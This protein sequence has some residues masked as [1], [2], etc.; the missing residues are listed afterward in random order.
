MKE[1]KIM[2]KCM[3]I[4][5]TL[6]LTMSYVT[7]SAG[8]NDPKA[9]IEDLL[10][11]HR[12]SSTTAQEHELVDAEIAYNN[13]KAN[14]NT[15]AP[16]SDVTESLLTDQILNKQ[17]FRRTCELEYLRGKTV[18][19][20]GSPSQALTDL[21]ISFNAD[22][23]DIDENYN[24]SDSTA[25]EEYSALENDL[26]SVYSKLSQ[27]LS[28]ASAAGINVL[29]DGSPYTGIDMD[30]VI[31]TMIAD[32]IANLMKSIGSVMF[33]TKNTYDT[34]LNGLFSDANIKLIGS[35]F[36][37]DFADAFAD[38]A[39]SQAIYDFMKSDN[40]L[41][42]IISSNNLSNLFTKSAETANTAISDIMAEVINGILNLSQMSDAKAGFLSTG[43]TAKSFTDAIKTIADVAEEQAGVYAR[44][45]NLNMLFGRY[46]KVYK[47]NDVAE[48]P[49]LL[50]ENHPSRTYDVKV[51]KG[52]Y[53]ASIIN[54]IKNV[55]YDDAAAQTESSSLSA[56][57]D[58]GELTFS[59]SSI[60]NSTYYMNIYRSGDLS[61]SVDFDTV[62]GY[63]G[64]LEIN[65][66]SEYKPVTS[67]SIRQGSEITIYDGSSEKLEAKISPIKAN[68]TSVSWSSSD[69][70][71][72]S[73]SSSGTIRGEKTG[74]ATITVTTNDG[75]HTASIKVT[76]KRRPGDG[77]SGGGVPKPPVVDG[78]KG[79]GV[80]TDKFTDVPETHWASEQINSLVKKGIIKGRTT[81][82]FDP[83]SPLTR[84]ELAIIVTG[85]MNIAPVE[86]GITYGDTLYHY[87]KNY[88][89]A[90]AKH[91]LMIGYDENS[92]NPDA[93]VTREQVISVLLRAV[94]L[95]GEVIN[96]GIAAL[97][98]DQILEKI[99]TIIGY[100]P[101][102]TITVYTDL[103][104]CSAWA[105]GYIE[106]AIA[107]GLTKGYEDNTIRP[108]VNATRAEAVVMV[109][110]ALGK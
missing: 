84:A 54:L 2:K 13:I 17:T 55:V 79:D 39:T 63:I 94:H 16:W 96:D 65:V 57:N 103:D 20:S 6:L 27:L 25:A 73:V 97:G 11:E 47:D 107:T 32:K 31:N 78:G 102:G 59:F 110:R 61:A 18:T 69:S 33:S 104:S 22:N 88:I 52:S 83:E 60:P 77:G 56:S 21:L 26:R 98:G 87:A 108:L 28:D 43:L 70:K 10:T 81:E 3:C 44:I 35:M 66:E 41:R 9:L 7:V 71:I 90:A 29:V 100:D 76:V 19:L 86:D 58:L 109:D 92:F 42:K 80:Y 50:D 105:K 68:S 46:M 1:I 37:K 24:F 82:T 106:V 64:S 30:S 14:A 49:I 99:I 67:V 36:G 34:A 12:E 4:I 53:S 91:G 72:V 62:Y 38:N 93:Y 95:K 48:L 89:S 8:S 40:F 51:S 75:G 74:T 85:M 101:R 45:I 15:Q 5:L 23:A